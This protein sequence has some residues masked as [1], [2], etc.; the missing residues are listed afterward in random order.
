LLPLLLLLFW[1]LLVLNETLLLF[2]ADVLAVDVRLLLL[3]S[4][5]LPV[6]A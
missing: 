2:A 1:L 3:L 4:R 6:E 5:S